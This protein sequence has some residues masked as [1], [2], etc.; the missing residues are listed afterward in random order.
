MARTYRPRLGQP[1]C[2][3]TTSLGQKQAQHGAASGR[4]PGSVV[5]DQRAAGGAG[6]HH[7]QLEL[8]RLLAVEHDWRVAAMGPD[9]LPRGAVGRTLPA[10]LRPAHLCDAQRAQPK[11][12]G[13]RLGVRTHGEVD[14]HANVA[15]IQ[16]PEVARPVA[17]ALRL[18]RL[19]II[20]VECAAVGPGAELHVAVPTALRRRAVG[21]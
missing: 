10:R 21:V 4:G 2:L 14:S 1:P 12:V 6:C 7:R 18:F 15:H 16:I 20:V 11:R 17:A 3:P 8:Q 19:R 5:A 13:A 9:D